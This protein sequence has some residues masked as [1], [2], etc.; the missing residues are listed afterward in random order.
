MNI[1]FFLGALVLAL[2]RPSVSFAVSCPLNT[3]HAYKIPGS[4]A[5]YYVDSSCKKR[6]FRNA[7]IYK[8][9]FSSWSEVGITTLARLNS[10]PNHELGFMP[11]GPLYDPKYGALVKT[12]IDPKVYFLLNGKKYWVTSEPVFYALRYQ[13]NWIEDIDPRLLDKYITG[14]EIT[15]ITKH[16]DGTI[17][18]YANSP[19]VY[20]LENGQKRKIASEIEFNSLGYRWDRIVVIADTEVYSNVGASV[21]PVSVAPVTPERTRLT[22]NDFSYVGAFRLPKETNGGSRFG[23]GGGALALNPHG[24]AS[25]AADGYLGS[26]YIVGHEHHQQVAEVNIPIPKD[27][28]SSS[29]ASLNTAQF[30]HG[31]VD[32]TEGKGKT[33]DAGNGWRLDGLAYLD[34]QGA[35]TSG[36]VYWTARTYYNVDTSNDLSHGYS[37]AN[38]SALNAQGMWR[39]GDFTGMMTGGYIFSVPTYFADSYL[40]GKR[41]ISGLFTQ[42]GVSATSQGP[43]MF[44]YAPWLESGLSNG[45]KLSTQ[46]LLYYPYKPIFRGAYNDP[47]S[48]FPDHQVPDHWEAAAFVNTPSKHAVVVVGRRAMGE[49]FYG[50]GRATDC[51]PY[52]GY[53]GEPYEPRIVFYD[54]A[55][56]ALAAQGKKDP[57]TIVPYFEW[58]PSEFVS[59]TCEGELTGAVYDEQNKLLYVLHTNADR[60]GGEPTPLVYVFR[61]N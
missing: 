21:P 7:F 61:V 16:L 51:D 34:A 53:H 58:N 6:P 30:L 1:L 39:L 17:I 57:T 22:K 56:L 24:D 47:V 49:T 28:R 37:D 50:D 33:F 12:V 23:F 60:V 40:G 54:P 29:V 31:F 42:Q 59:A 46:A 2:L 55:D 27:Q 26:L 3:D 9:Y 44:A 38:L 36:K 11:L 10:V 5:V 19:D 14:G 41:L 35:Q 13:W 8:T 32:I 15:D 25:G 18:K 20:I 48:N 4:S 43:A 45:K 52:K